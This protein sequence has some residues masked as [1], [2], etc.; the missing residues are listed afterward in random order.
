MTTT[1]LP[2]RSRSGPRPR[3][4]AALVLPAAATLLAL[5]NYTAPIATLAATG[6]D[7]GAGATAQVWIMSSISLG[8]AAALLAVGSLA[9]DHGRRRVFVLGA[10]AL[11]VSS[12][13]CAAAPGSAV[14]VAGRVVQG[15]ASAG[16]LATGLGII[17]AAFPPGPERTRATGTWGGMVGLGIALGPIAA[18]ALAL[19]DWRWWY[20][21]T[22]A[23]SVALAITG[24]RTL[25]ESRAERR[26][27]LDPAGLVTMVSGVAALLTAVTLGR[28]GWDRPWVL[29]LLAAA[30]VLLA[31]F[32]AVQARVREPMLDLR[33]F[34]RPSFLLSVTGALVTGLAIIGIMSYLATVMVLGLGMSAVTAAFVLAV[35]SVLSWIGAVQARRLSARLSAGRLLA[36]ALALNAAG[37]LAMLGL[38]PDTP[39]WRLVPGLA[40]AG[41]GSGLG[42]AMLARLAVESVPADR[43]SMGS[44]ANNTAR[45]IGAAL[46]VAAVVAIAGATGGG[47]DAHALTRGTNT[48]LLVS[49]V[50]ALLG[51]AFAALLRTERRA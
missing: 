40:L 43:A 31:A 27:G 26:R 1:T 19:A 2:R 9:D 32:V 12:V 36:V 29:G 48:A 46:G 28:D 3:P 15:A 17:A 5:M 41:V 50:L 38:A 35:W 10:A 51:A 37:E 6:A 45:Y 42:N 39:W 20:W 33:L 14:F 22:A 16:L 44:G 18:A 7:L 8:L 30:A 13:V 11:A 23:A 21:L 25:P 4:R 24:R 49:A 47:T 34:T